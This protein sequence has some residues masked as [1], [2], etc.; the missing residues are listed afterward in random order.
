M[1]TSDWSVGSESQEARLPPTAT[2]WC[3]VADTKC[4][5]FISQA[6]GSYLA[7]NIQTALSTFFQVRA[8]SDLLEERWTNLS[9]KVTSLS[10][11]RTCKMVFVI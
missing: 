5:H 1:D 11:T 8:D 2:G 10:N 9:I 6:G 7:P 3:Q 4:T